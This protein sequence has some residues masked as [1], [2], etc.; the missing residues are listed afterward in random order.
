MDHETIIWIK[1]NNPFKSKVSI[2]TDLQKASKEYAKKFTPPSQW[3]INDERA[4][5]IHGKRHLLR[6]GIYTFLLMKHLLIE[7]DLDL[8]IIAGVLHDIRRET[9][10]SD[11][12]HAFKSAEWFISNVEEITAQFQIKLSKFQI[13]KIYHAI[14]LHELRLELIERKYLDK[15]EH[16]INIIKTADALDRYIQPKLKW[17]LDDKFL[18]IK[19]S[20]HLKHFAF[21]L[22]VK[23]EL[24]FLN[25]T[26][27]ELSIFDSIPL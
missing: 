9:D 6:V 18:V 13:E 2:P 23:S 20:T 22:I 8:C 10:G 12:G 11:E 3:F 25:N 21:E 17:W 19:P 14:L 15:F 26:D 24:N 4:K 7:E 1:Q 16:I 27:S 5:T